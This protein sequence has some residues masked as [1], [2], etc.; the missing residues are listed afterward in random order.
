MTKYVNMED[1]RGHLRSRKTSPALA[2]D[3]IMA[4]GARYEKMRANSEDEN[5]SIRIAGMR[6]YDLRR[7]LNLGSDTTVQRSLNW[8]ILDELIEC[9]YW[10]HKDR[11]Y[12]FTLHGLQTYFKKSKLLEEIDSESLFDETDSET[13]N[14][15]SETESTPNENE[16]SDTKDE[17]ATATDSALSLEPTF[18]DDKTRVILES[19]I[20]RLQVIQLADKI[21]RRQ[22]QTLISVQSDHVMLMLSGNHAEQLDKLIKY[23]GLLEAE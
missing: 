14:E 7:A 6:F 17:N 10:K 5:Y 21:N 20:A 11:R 15:K 12:F 23:A 19:E 3:I 13:T 8:L 16:L 9:E 18:L 1:M 4:L 2:H 22:G